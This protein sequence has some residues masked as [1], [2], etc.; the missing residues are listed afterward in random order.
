MRSVY[1]ELSAREVSANGARIPALGFGTYGMSA[2]DIH[3]MVPAAL[4]A[5][6]RHLDTGA[7][8]ES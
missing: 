4:R 6:F 8:A 2:S 3:R 5:G 1:D 7:S